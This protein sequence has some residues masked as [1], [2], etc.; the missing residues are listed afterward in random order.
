[1]HARTH[2]FSPSSTHAQGGRVAVRCHCTLFL[3]F[4]TV[5]VW[6]WELS[7]TVLVLASGTSLYDDESD[8]TTTNCRYIPESQVSSIL[9][10]PR[11]VTYRV[12]P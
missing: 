8:R 10:F 4:Y 9:T 12:S 2:R 6:L 5:R 3:L 7:L 11:L 1:M